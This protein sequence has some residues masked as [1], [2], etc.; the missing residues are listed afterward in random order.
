M[1]ADLE[2]VVDNWYEHLDK[3]QRFKVVAFDE[4]NELVSVQH[5][6]G[7]I[8]EV[9]LSEWYDWELEVSEEPENWSG[10]IDVTEVD[11]YGTEVTDTAPEDWTEPLAELKRPRQE[12]LLPEELESSPDEWAEGYP[13]EQPLETEK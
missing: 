9:A 13:E 10:P 1:T 5:F 8:E 4:D 3:G 11:D 12:K 2:P 6:D 7:D